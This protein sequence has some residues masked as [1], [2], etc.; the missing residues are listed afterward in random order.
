MIDRSVIYKRDPKSVRI[1][2]NE[3]TTLKLKV[4]S[5][6]QAQK[7]IGE[8]I[9]SIV[10]SILHYCTFKP[11]SMRS[12]CKMYG[13]VLPRAQRE[14]TQLF[15]W[16]CGAKISSPEQLRRSTAVGATR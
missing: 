15:C 1:T 11:G 9:G 7:P 6:Q 4:V 3:I 13:H 8:R 16:D 10:R 14:G 2:H 5:S 12:Q